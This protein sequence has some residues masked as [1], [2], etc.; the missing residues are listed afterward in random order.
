M[1]TTNL[2]LTL[3]LFVIVLI[4]SKGSDYFIQKIGTRKNIIPKRIY[5]VSKLLHFI[6]IFF[7]LM[8]LAIIWNMQLGGIMVFASSIFAVIGVALFAQWS[9]LSNLT[10]SIIIFFTFPARVGD[11]IK[12]I[13]GD[14]SL[15]GEIIEI[16]LFQIEILDADGNT[17]LYPNNLFIQK[18]IMKIKKEKSLEKI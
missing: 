12:V 10:S 6:I 5:Y 4:I 15:S 9:I 7:A 13:D 17:I 8:A 18:P 1:I 16:S 3:S 14:N 2:I 11:K